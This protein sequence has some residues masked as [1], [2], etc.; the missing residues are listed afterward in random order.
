MLRFRKAPF[1]GLVAILLAITLLSLVSSISNPP[2]FEQEPPIPLEIWVQKVQNPINGHELKLKVK[3][4][5]DID[6]SEVKLYRGSTFVCCVKDNGVAPDACAN[7]KMF[8]ACVNQ[9]ANDFLQDV[10]DRQQEV[11]AKGSVMKFTGHIGEIVNTSNL[12]LF[13]KKAFNN[14]KPVQIN[15]LLFSSNECDDINDIQK[16]KSLFI[17]E[18]KVVEDPDRTYNLVTGNGNPIGAWT[19]GEMM[20]NMAGGMSQNP[21]Q[22]EII[23]MN[24]FLKEWIKSLYRP[25]QLNGKT[26]EARNLTDVIHFIIDPWLKKATG[27]SYA[28]SITNWESF[29]DDIDTQSEME[30]LLQHAPFKLTAIVNRLDL[31]GNSAYSATVS[32]AGET[33]FV[34][35]LIDPFTGQTPNHS[36]TA[37]VNVNYLDWE[38]MNVILEYG[39]PETNKCDVKQKAKDWIALSSY[40]WNNQSEFDDY[41]AALQQLTDDVTS[42]N[43]NPNQPNG[44]AINQVRTNEKLLAA[45]GHNAWAGADWELRQY[46]LD[47]NTGQL[48]NAPVTNVP[49]SD[50]NYARNGVHFTTQNNSSNIT[51]WIY[52]VGNLSS[53]KMRVFHGNHNLP[54]NL[55]QPTAEI[56]DELMHYYGVD[57]WN[58]SFPDAVY[59]N[60][61]Y[62]GS[63]SHIQKKVRKQLSLNTCMGC[64]TSET[65]TAFTMIR[66]RGYG[67]PADYWSAIPSTDTGRFD[68][69]FYGNSNLG[70]TWDNY[71][72][73]PVPNYD[74]D[75]YVSNGTADRIIPVVSPFLTGRNFRGNNNW[76][77]DDYTNPN[78]DDN[79]LSNDDFGDHEINGLFYVNDPS[80]E[81]DESDIHFMY[82]PSQPASAGTPF[83]KLHDNRTGF[84]DLQR[85]QMDLCNLA[86]SCCDPTLCPDILSLVEQMAFMPLSKN[87]H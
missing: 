29:W 81:S 37:F 45:T 62:T 18:L 79:D 73:A 83:P 9:N 57:F 74:P 55:T 17:T 3:F 71:L 28:I 85:R 16:H 1:V 48:T 53:Q 67:E 14:F 43:A 58:S 31:R 68:N 22:A 69:R 42:A 6:Q 84:N 54:D 64:H 26:A 25:Y 7:D 41:L 80:N 75:Y 35:S 56:E 44:S 70:T 4:H 40:D 2:K 61:N 72:N 33:R 19:F 50:E 13:D 52:G 27:N 82:P 49:F 23:E 30:S 24:L 63:S 34:F 39:N 5:D 51:D 59:D 11:I 38:G 32:N 76:E 78:N 12:T 46:E 36:N 86:N 66:P 20:K 8:T 60:D 65:K 47:V 10:L 87:A 77:D 21:S 15:P